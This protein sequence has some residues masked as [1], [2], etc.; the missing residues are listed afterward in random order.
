[1]PAR[2]RIANYCFALGIVAAIAAYV[3][4]YLTNDGSADK[5]IM[6]LQR[7]DQEGIAGQHASPMLKKLQ[8]TL[9]RGDIL[10]TGMDIAI[11]FPGMRD[12]VAICV[13]KNTDCINRAFSQHERVFVLIVRR[14][15]EYPSLEPILSPEKR[16]ASSNGYE[17]YGPFDAADKH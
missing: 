2:E 5:A 12:H 11:W 13:P 7:R 16:I 14:E 4:A 15:A 6:A 10:L 3:A 17:L 1:M 9:E 8:P